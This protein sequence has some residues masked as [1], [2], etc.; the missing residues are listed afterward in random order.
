MKNKILFK[1]RFTIICA[2]MC[3]V[4]VFGLS[5]CEGNQT[6]TPEASEAPVLLANTVIAE[7]HLEPIT[8]TWLSFQTTG[9]VEAVLVQEGDEVKQGQPLVRLE[10]SDRAESELAAA[11]SALFLAE[12][13]LNDTRN[14]DALRGAAEL[15]LAT[16][17]REYNRALYNYNSR[18]D[19]QGSAEQISLY[20]ARVIIAQ[21]KVDE[22]QEDL[23]GMAE[24]SD[25]DVL[26]NQIIA[27]LSQAQMELDD[28][29]DNYNYYKDLPDDIDVD[30]LTAEL[31]IATARVEDAQRDLDRLKDG[32]SKESLAALQTAADQAQASVDNAQ[33]AYDQL[34]L[35]APYNGVFVQ[36]DL[37]VGEFVTVGQRVALVADFSKWQIESD[38]LDEIEINQIDASKP[39]SITADAIPDQEYTGEV[40][41][42]SQ[43]YT[44]DN[45]DILY[46]AKVRL[47]KKDDLLRWG[48][49]M[50]MEFEK[51]D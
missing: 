36:C 17:Q 39:V 35:K 22:L 8:S 42:I 32:P 48:M 19:P 47:D 10:G 46:T 31:D 7:G 25:D 37:T 6:K 9:R 12:Q 3:M 1:N 11:Q 29:K 20:K 43:Y 21:D 38:D 2:F 34:V 13:N 51:K 50:Q 24:T 15:E 18:V 4:L 26:K 33:W 14:S 49:T 40:D 41:Q 5:G 28:T 45:G 23:N 16:A 27:K 44:D 30:R